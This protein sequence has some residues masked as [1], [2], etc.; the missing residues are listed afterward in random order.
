MIIDQDDVISNYNPFLS[1][2][3]DSASHINKYFIKPKIDIFFKENNIRS[4]QEL[5]YKKYISD[6]DFKRVDFSIFYE[7][8]LNDI[9]RNSKGEV[10]VPVKYCITIDPFLCQQHCLKTKIKYDIIF[11]GR[12]P[13]LY[14]IF[15]DIAE[16]ME[17]L[18][19]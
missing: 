9:Q 6:L 16:I 17:F 15:I 18:R 13:V 10:V 14:Y 7:N 3:I 8:I 4:F 11:L 5:D 1:F 19:R 2:S 12:N